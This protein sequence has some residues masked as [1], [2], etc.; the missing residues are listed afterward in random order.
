[1]CVCLANAQSHGKVYSGRLWRPFCVLWA[2][3]YTENA[4]ESL[5]R[6]R[7]VLRH[8]PEAPSLLS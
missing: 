4:T 2:V 5:L 1:M 6:H 7:C 8:G 3:V